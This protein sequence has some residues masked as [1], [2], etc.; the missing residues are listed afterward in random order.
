[1]E[2][3]ETLDRGELARRTSLFSPGL[4]VVPSTVF[5]ADTFSS[6]RVVFDRPTWEAVMKGVF[7]NNSSIDLKGT[8]LVLEKQ[9]KIFRFGMEASYYKEVHKSVFPSEIFLIDFIR[10][11]GEGL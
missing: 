8:S 1:I 3:V 6:W 2:F 4:S 10:H 9:G 11:S 5:T 7:V